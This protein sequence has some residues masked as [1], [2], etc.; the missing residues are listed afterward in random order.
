MTLQEI[1][2]LDEN[3]ITPE[4]AAGVL[5]CTPQSIR[6]QV[7]VDPG[8]LGF[9]VI[10]IGTRCLIPRIPFL[11]FMGVDVAAFEKSAG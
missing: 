3:V 8:K 9:P 7:A 2:N 4:I 10:K 6:T 1:R 5:R 11:R